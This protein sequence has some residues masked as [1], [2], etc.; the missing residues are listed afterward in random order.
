MGLLKIKLAG[1]LVVFL[2]KGAAGNEDSDGHWNQ[3]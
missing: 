3:K 1:A 2:I